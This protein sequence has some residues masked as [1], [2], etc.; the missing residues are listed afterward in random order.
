MPATELRYC[1]GSL[2]Q[3]MFLSLKHFDRK[4]CDRSGL[5]P[6]FSQSA[7]WLL[8][9]WRAPCQGGLHIEQVT[10]ELL[11]TPLS[12]ALRRRRTTASGGWNYSPANPKHGS[13]PMNQKQSEDLISQMTDIHTLQVEGVRFNST[14][15]SL[16]DWTVGRDASF[17][18]L[19][20]QQ[21]L[22]RYTLLSL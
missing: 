13:K 4:L 15:C 6:D 12:S 20:K 2:S 5:I 11:K 18:H 21:F 10:H 1:R 9:H 3:A 22:P 7:G 17:N 14:D 8:F 19:K 16:S